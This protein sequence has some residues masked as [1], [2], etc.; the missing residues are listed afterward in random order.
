MALLSRHGI[1][2]PAGADFG[3]VVLV[4]KKNRP[5]YDATH[6]LPPAAGPTIWRDMPVNPQ[7][8]DGY[9]VGSWCPTPDGS[10][11]PTAVVLELD[12][13]KVGKVVM[14]FKSAGELRRFIGAL[15]RHLADVWPE[16][17]E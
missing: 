16:A 4:S 8:V 7:K 2:H 9:A 10:G 3:A 14:R 5:D 15:S 6:P 1:P 12:L 11:K 17:L 13:P